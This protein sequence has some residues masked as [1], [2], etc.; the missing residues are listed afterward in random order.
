MKKDR[1]LPFGEDRIAFMDA[2]GV[3]AQ[4]MG[5]GNNSPMHLTKEQRGVELCKMANDELYEAAQRYPGRLYG[6]ATLPLCDVEE[7]VK[8]VERCVKEL[9]FV[10]VIINGQYQGK[11]I[12]D[13]AFFPILEKIAE[14]DVCLYIHP[15]EVDGPI[16][17]RYYKGE[18]SNRVTNI[19]S[20]FGIGWHYEVGMQLMRVILSG[21]FDKLPNLKVI[22]G[23]WGELLPY[24]FDRMN[25]HMKPEITGLSHEIMYYFDNNIYT[26]PSGMFYENDMDFCLK[27]MN[28]DHILWAQ[29]Y[30]YGR[31]D[32]RVKTFLEGYGLDH[33]L[34]EDIAH[35]N[36]EKLFKI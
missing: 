7:A 11:F 12:D 10:G 4:I 13:P 24:Y 30:P 15:N 27:V 31:Q 25:E 2:N 14:L 35:N 20:G 36:A 32:E 26:D 17:D 33:H 18:W 8:E 19:F 1:F 3:S 23:H 29:D 28:P 9:G 6:Y 34:M 22:V 16:L 5:Y 21:A